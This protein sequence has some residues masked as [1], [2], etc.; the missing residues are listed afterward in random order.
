MAPGSEFTAVVEIASDA[1][2]NAFDLTLSYP[3]ELELI[4]FN[5]AGSVVDLWQRGP[6]VRPDRTVELVGGMATPFVGARGRLVGLEFRAIAEGKVGFSWGV[7][8]FYRADGR[9]T[10][11]AGVGSGE[12]LVRIETGAPL[13]ALSVPADVTRPEVTIV[14]VAVDEGDLL[15]AFDA[16]DDESGIAVT[17]VRTRE[18]FTWG[19]WQ[20]AVNPVALPR[21]VWSAEL[22]AVNGSGVETFASVYVWSGLVRAAGFL[23]AFF[24]AIGTARVVYNKRKHAQ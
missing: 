7:V 20:P 10:E 11:V 18:W 19:P 13:L 8:H 15:L 16:R 24:T 21:G 17:L 12:S 22:L 6:R 9:G 5:T 23:L 14:T 1:A 2:V 3:S 4:G